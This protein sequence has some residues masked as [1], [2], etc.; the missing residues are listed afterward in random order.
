MSSAIANR[1][2]SRT[3]RPTNLK[4]QVIIKFK[5]RKQ[6]QC[7]LSN[8]KT[9]QNKSLNLTQL[10]FSGKLFVSESMCHE[11]HQLAYKC[12]ELKSARKIHSTWFYYFFSSFLTAIWLPHGQ[13]WAILTKQMLIPAFLNILNKRSLEAS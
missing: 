12:R 13:L 7:V 4:D 3:R 10:K 1:N 11:N 8:R 6:K 5:S 9:L 2:I